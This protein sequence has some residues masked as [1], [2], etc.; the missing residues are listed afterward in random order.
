MSIATRRKDWLWCFLSQGSGFLKVLS[1]KTNSKLCSC[2]PNIISCPLHNHTLCEAMAWGF[3][4]TWLSGVLYNWR[5]FCFI[6]SSGEKCR[7][8]ECWL[9]IGR[10]I[11]CQT[12]YSLIHNNFPKDMPLSCMIGRFRYFWLQLKTGRHF[13]HLVCGH[14]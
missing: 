10:Q 8:Q 2:I 1:S 9:F 13:P 11:W 12:R 4:L 7:I 14:C 5:T 6:H 3:C